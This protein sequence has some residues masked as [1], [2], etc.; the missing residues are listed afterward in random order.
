MPLGELTWTHPGSDGPPRVSDVLAY[1]VERGLYLRR[2][3][4]GPGST[5]VKMGD[6]S[7]APGS[8]LL[9]LTGQIAGEAPREGE[10]VLFVARKVAEGRLKA[11]R[12]VAFPTPAGLAHEGGGAPRATAHAFRVQRTEISL[13]SGRRVLAW[14]V[15]P[16]LMLTSFALPLGVLAL[17]LAPLLR[18]VPRRVAS[19]WIAPYL[20]A[21]AMLSASTA[22]AAPA[23]VAIASLWGS[24]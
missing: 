24:R 1:D 21:A 19:A 4:P 23:V 17:L 13:T 9:E 15:R 20:E 8:P 10:A 22:A 3:D 7:I 2:I 11:V 16:L 6:P 18:R 12:I 14:V 5:P